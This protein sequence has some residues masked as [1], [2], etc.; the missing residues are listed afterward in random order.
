MIIITSEEKQTKTKQKWNSFFSLLEQNEMLKRKKKDLLK[1]WLSHK[2]KHTN[3]AIRSFVSFTRFILF[4]SVSFVSIFFFI[5]LNLNF[6]NMI[7]DSVQQFVFARGLFA[8]CTRCYIHTSVTFICFHFTIWI[9]SRNNRW[10]FSRDAYF[11]HTQTVFNGW[12]Q[13]SQS[14]TFQLQCFCSFVFR[15]RKVLLFVAA[16]V[17]V[18]K[19]PPSDG[20]DK[21]KIYFFFFVDCTWT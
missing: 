6:W 15:T 2:H 14:V 16:I 13:T 9:Y 5:F 3:P 20:F 12:L 7:F 17:F 10:R 8:C 19:T 21:M 1:S 18:T 11:E 4:I